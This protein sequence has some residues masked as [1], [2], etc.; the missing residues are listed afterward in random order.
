MAMVAVS[1]SPI[2]TGE[3]S[4]S[5]FVAE[6]ERVIARYPALNYRLDPMF[7]T[8]EGDLSTIFAAIQEMHEALV[9][10][11]AKR[12]S[13]VIKIDDRRD[14][15]HSMDEKVAAV[16]AKLNGEGAHNRTP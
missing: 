16:L 12:L 14:V 11:G 9:A 15:H 5:H 4:V 10:M 8:I 6:A 13:T 3:T 7:T 2:G 1:I